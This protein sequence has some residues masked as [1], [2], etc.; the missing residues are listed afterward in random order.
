MA[1]RG[2]RFLVEGSLALEAGGRKG[3][4]SQNSLVL[5]TVLNKCVLNTEI[6]THLVGALLVSEIKAIALVFGL[7]FDSLSRII[8]CNRTI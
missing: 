6:R 4:I 1:G 8:K 5:E 7:I 2:G 3:R